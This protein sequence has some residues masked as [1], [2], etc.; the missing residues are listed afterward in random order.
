MTAQNFRRRAIWYR[1]ETSPGVSS[2]DWQ[3]ILYI[4]D[5]LR[6]NP[7]AGQSVERTVRRNSLDSLASLRAGDYATIEFEC[8][9]AGSGAAGTAPVW[10][11]LAVACALAET[12]NAA[13]APFAVDY[14]AGSTGIVLTGLLSNADGYYVGRTIT[15]SGLH[16]GA[17]GDRIVTAYVGAT[18]RASLAPALPASASAASGTGT[19]RADVRYTPASEFGDGSTAAFV[20][21]V[22]ALATPGFD[23]YLFKW[24]RGNLSLSI[25]EQAVPRLKFAFSAMLVSK[26]TSPAEDPDLGFS[27]WQAPQIPSA[28]NCAVGTVH[29]YEGAILQSFDLDCGVKVAPVYRCNSARIDITDRAPTG[30]LVAEAALLEETDWYDAVAQHSLGPVHVRLG[31]AAGSIVEVFSASA[32]FTST[33]THDNADGIVMSAM[34]LA[35]RANSDAGNDSFYIIAR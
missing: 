21:K 2:G 15:L 30:K 27:A 25:Q 34:D 3:P 11:G 5:T 16:G 32:Q 33:P 1:A 6:V 29:G 31:A 14:E 26:S 12:A 20:Y 7:M 24:G 19:R 8:E 10:G 28:A 13:G 17:G 22:P 4:A 18:K 23:R 9:L 35:F